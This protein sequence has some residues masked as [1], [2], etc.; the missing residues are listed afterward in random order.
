MSWVSS[1]LLR[2]PSAAC[3]R[4]RTHWKT[5]PATSPTRRPRRSSAS[6][7]VSSISFRRPAL[8][9]A[10]RRQ[11]H[12]HFAQHQ[13]GAGRR[14]DRPR[15]PP[16]WRSTAPASSRCKSPAPSPTARRCSTASTATP[17]A[18]TSRS[19][20]AAISS[21]APATISQGVPVDPTTGNLTGSSPQVLK[22][23]NDFL[24]AQETTKIDYRANLASYPLTTA[25]RQVDPGIGIARAGGL[26][27]RS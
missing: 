9:N 4:S 12:H 19:T 3:A 5:S 23:Q 10:A 11:R 24:P 27:R 16:T 6:T 17:A 20:R 7:P 21:T 18:A 22:F 25:A 13:H 15:S 2:R 8:T 26:Q 1:A 14:A